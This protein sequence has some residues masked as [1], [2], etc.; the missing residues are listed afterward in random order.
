M[1]RG[2]GPSCRLWRAKQIDSGAQY[3]K[4]DEGTDRIWTPRH[5]LCS[6]LALLGTHVAHLS[7]RL[8]PVKGK[9]T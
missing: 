2:N 3:M 4:F 7:S 1:G 8:D 9:T 5:R 6:V